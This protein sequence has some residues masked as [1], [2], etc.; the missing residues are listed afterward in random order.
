MVLLLAVRL[1]VPAL[2]NMNKPPRVISRKGNAGLPAGLSLLRFDL[3]LPNAGSVR[4]C[5]ALPPFPL[6]SCCLENHGPLDEALARLHPQQLLSHQAWTNLQPMSEA[7]FPML[8]PRQTIEE[9]CFCRDSACEGRYLGE[10]GKRHLC[11][12]ISWLDGESNFGPQ[13]GSGPLQSFVLRPLL[14]E[15]AGS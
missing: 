11:G 12:L 5:H 13:N 1:A 10:G 2:N 7:G 15:D 9:R 14:I 6:L 3:Q 4:P 8:Q